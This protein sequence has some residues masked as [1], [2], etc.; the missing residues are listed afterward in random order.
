MVK[1]I[2]LQLF[3]LLFIP[4]RVNITILLGVVIAIAT[5]SGIQ[6]QQRSAEERGGVI[7]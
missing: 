5:V 7:S 1:I 3:F 4:Q 6:L 2:N